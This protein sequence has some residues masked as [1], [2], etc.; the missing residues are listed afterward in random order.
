[1]RV[2]A[3]SQLAA[4]CLSLEHSATYMCGAHAAMCGQQDA[5]QLMNESVNN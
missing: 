2:A 1:M 3:R 5:Y 4:Y